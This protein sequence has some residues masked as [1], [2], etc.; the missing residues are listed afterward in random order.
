MMNNIADRQT[1]CPTERLPLVL[2]RWRV[3]LLARSLLGAL[4]ALVVAFRN[5]QHQAARLWFGRVLRE[6]T[7]LLRSVEPM[8]GFI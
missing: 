6:P 2:G 7:H 1:Q 8:L 4:G 5:R 3:R